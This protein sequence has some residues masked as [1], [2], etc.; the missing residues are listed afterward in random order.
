[1]FPHPI[2]CEGGRWV[3][4]EEEQAFYTQKGYEMR[5]GQTVTSA[6][7]DYL[8]MIC[9]QARTEGY[10]RINFLAQRL[11][12]RPSSASKMVYQLRDLGL[13]AFEKYGLIRPTSAGTE[14]GA[15]LLYRHDL[16]HR[17]FCWVNGTTDELEQVEQVEHYIRK[18]TLHNLE[19]L[20]ERC[21]AP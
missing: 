13:V 4:M 21:G 11:N 5:S 19:Q 17:F 3:T 12:V 15:Y 18:E 14:L 20:M 16:L 6:M 1:M 10:A 7:E 8:E 9:R 2:L